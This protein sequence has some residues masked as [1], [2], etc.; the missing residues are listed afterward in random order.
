MLSN[1][2]KTT[3]EC[4]WRTLGT[5][6]G[7]LFSSKG[8]RVKYKRQKRDK[9]LGTKTH[10]REGVVKEQKFPNTRKP[11][12]QQVCGSFGISEGNIT[13][14][15]KRKNPQNMRLTATPSRE[16]AQT[17]SSATGSRA[18]WTRLLHLWDFPGKSTRV[19]CHLLLQGILPIL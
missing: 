5:Q 6:K 18:G 11:S 1:F 3:S 19:G 9:E 7:I 17:L 4:W 14:R 13:G 2:H 10:P 8:G 12:R 16:V 15:E